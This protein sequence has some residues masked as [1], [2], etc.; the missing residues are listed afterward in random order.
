LGRTLAECGRANPTSKPSSKRAFR[1]PKLPLGRRGSSE[2]TT[3]EDLLA[4]GDLRSQC[5][6]G[7]IPALYRCTVWRGDSHLGDFAE[8]KPKPTIQ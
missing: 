5:Q 4:T 2:L 7:W 8:R 6:R 3:S 1:R